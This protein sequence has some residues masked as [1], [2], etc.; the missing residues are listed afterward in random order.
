MTK[1]FCNGYTCDC[2]QRVMVIRWAKDK[3]TP[4]EPLPG[5]QLTIKCAHC[6]RSRVLTWQEILDLPL[7]W[8][9]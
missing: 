4:P 2:G 9:E 3:P 7:V 5:Y 1:F 8:E 6:P